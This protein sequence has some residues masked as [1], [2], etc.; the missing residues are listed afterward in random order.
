M[1]GAAGGA[2]VRPRH[3]GHFRAADAKS[4]GFLPAGRSPTYRCPRRAGRH[5]TEASRMATAHDIRTP[6]L[7]YFAKHAHEPF[8]SSPPGPRHNP[9]LMLES[10]NVV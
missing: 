10:K 5:I 8:P 1:Y 6:F 4:G 7:D 3:C 9:T 2:P